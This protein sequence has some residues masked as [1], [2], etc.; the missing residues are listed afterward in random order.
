MSDQKAMTWDGDELVW[1]DFET[2]E[3]TERGITA[4]NL[5][6]RINTQPEGFQEIVFDQTFD[7][8]SLGAKFVNALTVP[9]N[10]SIKFLGIHILEL[11]VAGGTTVKLAL[12][13]NADLATQLILLAAL[14]KNT[15]STILRDPTPIGGTQVVDICG[16][17]TAGTALENT[18]ISAGRVRVLCTYEIAAV[19]ADQ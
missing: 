17:T 4:K 3:T 6:Q 5:R 18:N 2:G 12:G 9:S 1:N 13:D 8:T 19:L 15:K 10:A 11:V 14:T 16:V 7:L